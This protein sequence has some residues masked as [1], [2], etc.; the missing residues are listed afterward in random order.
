MFRGVIVT[1]LE[2]GLDSVATLSKSKDPQSL[3]QMSKLQQCR[4]GSFD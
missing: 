2:T 4:N 3:N 1:L